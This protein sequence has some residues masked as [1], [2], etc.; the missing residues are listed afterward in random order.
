[1]EYEYR[2]FSCDGTGYRS[3][4]Y[5]KP[6]RAADLARNLSELFPGVRYVVRRCK[7]RH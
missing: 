1:M 5:I 2:V 4:G 6:E 3:V 7:V